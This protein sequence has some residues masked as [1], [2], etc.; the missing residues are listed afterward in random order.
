MD[1]E[2]IIWKELE[3]NYLGGFNKLV[4]KFEPNIHFDHKMIKYEPSSLLRRSN[5]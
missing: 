4:I 5:E 2:I 3:L 1:E